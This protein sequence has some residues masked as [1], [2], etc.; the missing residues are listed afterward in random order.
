M[1]IHERAFPIV[2]VA[3]HPSRCS[4]YLDNIGIAVVRFF[5]QINGRN[6][7]QG[8]ELLIKRMTGAEMQTET[9]VVAICTPQSE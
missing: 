8:I 4:I 3:L 1:Y 5:E 2:I 9:E 6:G 7:Q